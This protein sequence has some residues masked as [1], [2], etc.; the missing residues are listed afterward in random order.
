MKNTSNRLM[1]LTPYYQKV[2]G[3]YNRYYFNGLLSKRIVVMLT[4]FPDRSHFRYGKVEQD[5]SF[6][7]AN[8]K[9]SWRHAPMA[10]MLNSSLRR[11]EMKLTLL[12][13]M[14]HIRLNDLHIS[15]EHGPRFQQEMLR[16]AKAGAFRKLW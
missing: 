13:E 5:V 7:R 4:K 16:L 3:Q 11:N 9:G 14:A 1:N 10:I 8:N 12:H 6:R 15:H 2:F